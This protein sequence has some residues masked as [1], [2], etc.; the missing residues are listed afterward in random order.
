MLFCPI[1][2]DAPPPSLYPPSH[3]SYSWGGEIYLNIKYIFSNIH[4]IYFEYT[5]GEGNLFYCG[6]IYFTY[7]TYQWVIISWGGQP[8]KYLNIS[9]FQCLE[10]STKTVSESVAKGGYG[11]GRAAKT[12]KILFRDFWC[13][14][15][16]L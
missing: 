16:Q 14:R 15:E 2:G 3:R 11:A 13:R 12:I 4:Q 5:S 1:P 8:V 6:I 7:K 10:K 9:I